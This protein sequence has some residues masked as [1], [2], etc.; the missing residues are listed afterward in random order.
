LETQSRG[1]FYFGEK[2]TFLFWFNTS[3]SGPPKSEEVLNGNN[4][5]T[6]GFGGRLFGS[7]REVNVAKGETVKSGR[8]GGLLRDNLHIQPR[9]LRN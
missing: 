5:P 9:R 8:S 6:K 1:H 2:G 3:V 7:D 4:N